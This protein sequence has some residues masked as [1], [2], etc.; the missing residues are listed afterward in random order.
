M[1][2]ILEDGTGTGFKTKVD[3][4]N[5]LHVQS[6]SVTENDHSNTKG[7]AYNINSGIIT[8]TNDIDTPVIY[9]K[10]NEDLDYHLQNI[11]VALEFSTGGDASMTVITLVKNPTAGTLISNANAVDIVSNR[12]FGSAQEIDVDAYKGATGSTLTDGDDFLIYFLQ[13][14]NRLFASTDSVIPKEKSVAVKILPPPGNTSMR[15]YVAFV[16]YILDDENED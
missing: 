9:L 16:G 11:A 10:N 14:D 15:V 4:N 12:N 7:N 5:R 13:D 8:L 6:V 1:S 3:A 2:N